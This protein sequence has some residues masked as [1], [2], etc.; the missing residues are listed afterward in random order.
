MQSKLTKDSFTKKV[1]P[2]NNQTAASD[3]ISSSASSNNRPGA[4]P[5]R[6]AMK[7][8]VNSQEQVLIDAVANL[9]DRSVPPTTFLALNHCQGG[10][11]MS[12]SGDLYLVVTK[13]NVKKVAKVL[14]KHVLSGTFCLS[15]KF[16]PA[17]LDLGVVEFTPSEHHDV[18]RDW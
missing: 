4:N 5:D 18:I 13:D 16:D 2:D 11:V 3:Q 1:S 6:R 12:N 9:P 8:E 17:D 7:K 15:T 10:F 14:M